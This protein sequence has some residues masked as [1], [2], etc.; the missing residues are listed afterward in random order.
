VL[1]ERFVK[2]HLDVRLVL[3][4]FSLGLLF[5]E[6]YLAVVQT[7]CDLARCRE[8]VLRLSIN[9]GTVLVDSRGESRFCRHCVIGFLHCVSFDKT[10]GFCG[11]RRTQ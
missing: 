5:R 7:D 8:D 3:Q 11:W 2:Q 10:S 4:P 9:L 6:R 1:S